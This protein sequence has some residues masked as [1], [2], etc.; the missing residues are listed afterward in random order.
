M[1]N[2]S[3]NDGTSRG[4]VRSNEVAEKLGAYVD[5]EL[6]PVERE[7]VE[8][9]LEKDKSCL[10]IVQSFRFLDAMEAIRLATSLGGTESL[11]SHPWTM[12]PP[13]VPEVE[14]RAIGVTP[15]LIRLSVGVEDPFDLIADLDQALASI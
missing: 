8:M 15:G 13:S 2:G 7:A 1:Q 9:L 3:L 14:K 11:A 5:G 6:S 12:S 4:S 10:E